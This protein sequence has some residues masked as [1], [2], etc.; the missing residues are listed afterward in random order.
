MKHKFAP[1]MLALFVAISFTALAQT[2]RPAAPPPAPAGP[3]PTKLGIINIELAI[4]GSNEGQRD[5][6]A[7]QK[8]FEPKQNE[9]QALGKEVDDLKKQLNTQGDK[10]NDDARAG[11]VKSIE[12]K[13]KNLQ[14]SL[15]DAQT[16]FQNQQKELANQIGRKMLGVLDKYAK[17]RSF[18]VILDVSNPQSGVL[19]AGASTDVTKDIVDAY[20]AQS[21][22]PPP[23]A[24]AAGASGAARRPTTTPPSTK[25]N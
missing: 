4:V 6:A 18:A 19:W 22:V 15:E 1:Y 12:L 21:G 14:R 20:N 7:L 24:P 9:L 17:D 10:L 25:P 5:F 3:P 2:A 16:D 13:Q 11:L 8:R 23:P